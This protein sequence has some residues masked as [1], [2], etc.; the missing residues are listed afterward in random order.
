MVLPTVYHRCDIS[1]KGA[2]LPGRND[3]EMG[4]ANSLHASAYYSEYNERYDL[5]LLDK[6]ANYTAYPPVRT[7]RPMRTH[8]LWLVG[9]HQLFPVDESMVQ[10]KCYTTKIQLGWR[11]RETKMVIST[12]GHPITTGTHR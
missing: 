8:Q 6:I 4:P 9:A 7:R 3:V 12:I 2:V 5:I 10:W 1:L 11:T